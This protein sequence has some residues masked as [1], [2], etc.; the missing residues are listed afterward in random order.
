MR[1]GEALTFCGGSGFTGALHRKRGHWH[2]EEGDEAL[3]LCMRV[4]GALMPCKKERG[5]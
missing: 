4:K 2:S 5:E 1:E 3:V